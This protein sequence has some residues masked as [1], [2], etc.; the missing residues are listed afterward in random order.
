M[1]SV[2]EGAIG[3]G[4]IPHR[5]NVRP[6]RAYQTAKAQSS[7]SGKTVTPRYIQVR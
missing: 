2:T 6:E 1:T 3:A 5:K 4:S 7:D